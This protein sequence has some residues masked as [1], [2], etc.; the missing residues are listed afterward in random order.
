MNEPLFMKCKTFFSDRL[1]I[2]K[3]FKIID[4]KG[5]YE[6]EPDSHVAFMG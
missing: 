2:A 5:F 6:Y 3:P 4:S 1:K